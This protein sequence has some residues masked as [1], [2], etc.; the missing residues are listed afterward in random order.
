MKGYINNLKYKKSSNRKVSSDSISSSSLMKTTISIFKNKKDYSLLNQNEKFLNS[1]KK[2]GKSFLL[3]EKKNSTQLPKQRYDIK[4]YNNI[5]KESNKS[6]FLKSFYNPNAKYKLYLNN[7]SHSTI[8]QGSLNKRKSE[9]MAEFQKQINL[10]K[11][12]L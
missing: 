8:F 7:S 3:S 12:K 9:N 11:K 2:S 6:H 10:K 4:K 1:T 5:I